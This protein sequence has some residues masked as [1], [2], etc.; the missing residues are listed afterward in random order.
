[1]RVCSNSGLG[2]ALQE[3]TFG[4]NV[5]LNS[6]DPAEWAK[7]IKAVRRKSRNLRLKEAIELREKYAT[8]YQWERQCR[9][10]VQRMLEM[11]QC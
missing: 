2:Q 10:L 7:E 6:D 1:M 11:V 9:T 3:L 4:E 8:E 5:V